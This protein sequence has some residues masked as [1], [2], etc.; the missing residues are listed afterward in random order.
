MNKNIFAEWLDRLVD[1][2]RNLYDA[3]ANRLYRIR[4]RL[5]PVLRRL[6]EKLVGYSGEHWKR[7][8]VFGVLGVSVFVIGFT[9]V[10]FGIYLADRSEIVAELDQYKDWLQGRGKREKIP[11]IQFYAQNGAH[12]GEYLPH[13]DS[14]MT[15]NT[16]GKLEWLKRAAVSAEDRDFYNHSGV[17]VRGILRAVVSNVTSFSLREGGGSITQQLGRNLFTDRARS[18]T[19]KLYETFVAFLI[20]EK[21]SKDE[22]LCLY[23][24]KI[25][26]GKGRIGAEE[27]AWYYFRKPPQNLSAAEAAMIVGLFPSPVHYSPQ[28]NIRL[29]LKKQRLVMLTLQRDEYLS[30]KEKNIELQKFLK[31]YQVTDGPDGDAGQIGLYGASRDFRKNLAPTANDYIKETL[32]EKIPEEQIEA[33]GLKVYTTIDLTRQRAALDA[34]RKRVAA[35]RAKLLTN[36]K[37]PR[38]QM[39]RIARRMNGVFVAL[40]SYTGDIRA[41]VGG[42]AIREGNMTFRVRRMQ[43]QPGS[44]MKGVLYAT[45]FDEGILQINDVVI[46]E[47]INISGYKPRNWNHKYLGPVALRK[48]L[49]MSINTVAVKTLDDVGVSTFRDRLLSALDLSYSDGRNR[50]PANLSLALGSGEV[51]PLELARIYA[52]IENGGRVVYPRLVTRIENQ[53]GEVI[54][55]DYGRPDDGE[56]VLS[57]EA[58]S[59]AVRLME[60]VFD[61]EVEGTVGY[62]GKSRAKNPAYL[63]FPIAG[64]TGT[65]QSVAATY[66]KYPGMRGARDAWFVGL[67]PGEAAVVW[68]GHDEGAPFPGGGSNSAA[69]VWIEYAQRA[70]KGRVSDVWPERVR[71]IEVI[72]PVIEDPE[73]ISEEDPEGNSDSD[74]QVDPGE[75][76]DGESDPA[77]GPDGS[78]DLEP[79]TN[80]N[81]S[82]ANPEKQPEDARPGPAPV[83]PAD[84]S[85]ANSTPAKQPEPAPAPQP[86]AEDAAPNPG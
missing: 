68:M 35:V 17:S 54:W 32:Y 41:V 63:P 5:G 73:D 1:F 81:D 15:M 12:I 72:D 20:E 86:Q 26:M 44:V 2:S 60:S 65:V 76:A 55:Q 16:C 7:V 56:I 19:R 53:K 78:T 57:S 58:C 82:N 9:G 40:D 3:A 14:R 30:E 36:T 29:S 37:V 51:S 67:A 45:A 18:F 38:D 25:Y 39:E 71:E 47:R 22:I 34:I 84:S 4:L 59:Q 42:Y 13:R 23:L 52:M 8:I 64:K 50:F 48:A 28:N 49:A 46:D 75:A 83:G 21:F 10:V 33:G 11:P 62:V 31:R 66:K 80:P 27:A 79:E 6:F 70:L 74:P 43:R 69:P 85:D 77:A 61:P 24:N